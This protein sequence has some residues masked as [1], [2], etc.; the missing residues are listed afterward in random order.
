[1]AAEDSQSS[2]AAER[3]VAL[4]M[5]DRV[6]GSKWKLLGKRITLGADASYQEEEFIQA[7]RERKVAPHVHE[8]VKGNLDKNCL[9]KRERNDKRLPISQ[10]ERKLIERFFGW[11]KSNR[12]LRQVKL[13]GLKRV[14]WFHRLTTAA[15]NRNPLRP[16]CLK[17]R[18]TAGQGHAPP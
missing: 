1:V 4:T 15:S 10:K 13:H 11:S 8:Y 5:L 14:D 18:Q 3:H 12:L 2:N 17:T 7:L 16:A 9:T 6:V